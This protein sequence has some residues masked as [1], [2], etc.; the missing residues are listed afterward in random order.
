MANNNGAAQPVFP[1]AQE[2]VITEGLTNNNV[3][4]RVYLTGQLS[5]TAEDKAAELTVLVDDLTRWGIFR[6]ITDAVKKGVPTGT[7]VLVDA[8]GEELTDV[9]V[10][11]VPFY[12]KDKLHEGDIPKPAGRV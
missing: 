1:G 6:N 3:T 8:T 7:F 9:K 2:K 12:V 5:S 11:V 4:G 10:E